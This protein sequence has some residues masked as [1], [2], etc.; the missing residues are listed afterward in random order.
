MDWSGLAIYLFGMLFAWFLYK[1]VEKISQCL[2]AI[3]EEIRPRDAT[4]HLP[5]R[6]LRQTNHDLVQLGQLLREHH[7]ELDRNLNNLGALLQS[8]HAE[9]LAATVKP[10]IDYSL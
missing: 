10:P 2:A 4:N 8:Q 3:L 5:H 1:E 6:G 7:A 9:L